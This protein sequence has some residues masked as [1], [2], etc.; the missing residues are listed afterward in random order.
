[1]TTPTDAITFLDVI[2]E[3]D[4]VRTP[5]PISLN[6]ADVRSLAGISSGPISFNDLRGKSASPQVDILETT[7]NISSEGNGIQVCTFTVFDDGGLRAN[8]TQLG[9]TDTNWVQSGTPIGTNYEVR[10]TRTSGD[11]PTG[12]ALGTWIT[13]DSD[14]IWTLVASNS[15][16]KFCTLIVEIREI[17]NNSNIDSLTVTMDSTSTGGNPF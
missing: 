14:K 6:D 5:R 16:S 13:L 11:V 2:E 10:A 3:L 1:M 4:E 9:A 15:S 17:G 7:R 12:A 8:S